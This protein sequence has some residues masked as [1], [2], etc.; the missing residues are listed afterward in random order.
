[1]ALTLS[2]PVFQAGERIPAKYT[3]EGDDVSP[4]LTWAVNY[5]RLCPPKASFPMEP[6]KA[7]MISEDL[8]MVAL[9]LHP[10]AHTDINSLYTA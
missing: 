5:R 8:D 10:D 2:S 3:C 9:A 6:Y 7:R 4:A 1:M